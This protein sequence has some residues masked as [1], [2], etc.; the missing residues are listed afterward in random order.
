MKQDEVSN[1]ISLMLTC[2]GV[3]RMRE[4]TAPLTLVSSEL[5]WGVGE[6]MRR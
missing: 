6:G 4:D 3:H 1:V 2:S 5:S